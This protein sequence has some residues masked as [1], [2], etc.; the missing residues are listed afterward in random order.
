MG[1]AQKCTVCRAISLRKNF[2]IRGNPTPLQMKHGYE[3]FVATHHWG[4]VSLTVA[5]LFSP[6]LR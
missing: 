4:G 6:V 1:F 2:T 3:I 5:F